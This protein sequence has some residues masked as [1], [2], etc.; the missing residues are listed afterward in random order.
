MGIVPAS[1]VMQA[2]I[3]A[4]VLMQD[5]MDIT[6]VHVTEECFLAYPICN[7]VGGLIP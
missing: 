7:T 5:L 1:G 4:N 3:L 6:V 2:A